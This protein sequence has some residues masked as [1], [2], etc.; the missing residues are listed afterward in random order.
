MNM[1]LSIDNADGRGP[2]DYSAAIDMSHPPRVL[3]R[4]NKPAELRFS[5]LANSPDFIV[6]VAGARVR[7]GRLNGSDVFTGYLADAPAYE[8]L[9]WGENGAIFRY[10][11]SAIGDE[12][13]LD[14]KTLPDR[15]PFVDR[16]AGDA[17]R[18]LADNLLP[19]AFDTSGVQG[20]DSL[21]WYSCDRHKRWSEH[22][23]EIALRARAAYSVLNGRLT[24]TALGAR[25]Y[26]LDESN[27]NSSQ[28]ALQLR[29]KDRTL[30]DVTV[31]G[32][33][34]PQAHVKD[35]FVGDGLSLKF[36]LSQ[37]PFSRATRT[38]L[39]EEY[40][41]T[42]LN[43]TTWD[44]TDPSSSVRV[45]GG[46]LQV[47]GGTGRD[48]ETT[49]RFAEHLELGGAWVL[50]HGDVVFNAASNGV[51]GGLYSGYI[52]SAACLCGFRI[53]PAG[54]TSN[55]QAIVMG[56]LT[57][58][59]ITVNSSHRYI[60][61]TRL[62]SSEIYRRQQIFHSSAHPAANGRGGN[63]IPASLRIVLEVHDIDPANPGS[64][65]APSTVL[66]DGVVASAPGFC[67]YALVN[68]PAL[69]CSL[70][71]TRILRPSDIEVRSALPGQPYRTRLSGSLSEGAECRI[72]TE[73]AL[74]F[75]PAFTPAPN[76]LISV[77]YRSSG[78][79]AAR[80]TDPNSIGQHA[81]EVDD[82]LRGAVCKVK[83]PPPWTSAD[84]GL[85]A[86]ALLDECAAPGW[87]G[88]YQVW[89]DFLPGGTDDILPGD[90]LQVHAPSRAA[91][92]NAVIR[93][94]EVELKDL[95][96]E[97][98]LY[99]LRFAD[100]GAESLGLALETSSAA[101][102]LNLVENTVATQASQ[103]LPDLTAAEITQVSSTTM[104]MD[105]GCAP[106]AGGGIEARLTDYG[107]GPDND[108]NLLGRFSAQNFTLPRFGRAQTCYLRQFDNAS[109]PRYSRYS[110][111]LHID[112]PL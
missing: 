46:K 52:S 58:P 70:A 13:L 90:L 72:S 48:G 95:R 89:S 30:N 75:Y 53:V 82:G 98:D 23:A 19:G 79:A 96:G 44:S 40:K 10:D 11:I 16:S 21:G 49:V 66:Y 101:P 33:S 56:S 111:A 20:L 112:Y 1:T 59:V 9:G 104:T 34:E 29:P 81:R 5:L 45:T 51:L 78:R 103:F 43:S 42:A 37:T 73:P 26:S 17:L 85:A 91:S 106:P 2:R 108:R 47:T 22:A 35:Y 83:S 27:R 93:E 107:W 18:E 102:P 14:R 76:E 31:I 25:S 87:S 64:V 60:L 39:D 62:F 38:I 4:L 88:E 12:F 65:V 80:V 105:A 57:G 74:L 92:F 71:F 7:L 99:T 77:H 50:Q 54:A 86:L 97:H 110:A 67:I 6:P 15:P 32:N 100:E 28:Q 84:C 3:R 41:G 109:P 55:L 61:T 69:H 24:F 68:S 94:V 36:Y 8:Y 63:D